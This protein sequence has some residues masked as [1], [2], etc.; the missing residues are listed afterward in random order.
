MDGETYNRGLYAMENRPFVLGE[1]RI[2]IRIG[3]VPGIEAPIGV[4]YGLAITDRFFDSPVISWISGIVGVS[5]IW[6][7]LGV[8]FGRSRESESND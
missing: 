6:G 1:S 7:G 4:Y 3:S 8:L 5:V 2:A